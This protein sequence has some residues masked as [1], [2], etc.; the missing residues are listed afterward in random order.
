MSNRR[1]SNLLPRWALAVVLTGCLVTSSAAAFDSDRTLSRCETDAVQASFGIAA[2]LSWN[3][4]HHAIGPWTFASHVR[5]VCD[6]DGCRART[7]R[8]TIAADPDGWNEHDTASVFER[9]SV[10]ES[11]WFN[12]SA[13]LLAAMSNVTRVIYR[14]DGTDAAEIAQALPS[15]WTADDGSR[16]RVFFDDDVVTGIR[17]TARTSLA[18]AADASMCEVDVTTLIEVPDHASTACPVAFSASST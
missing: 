9:I 14:V 11:Q 17:I 3:G 8:A 4:D 18:C 10:P 6:E 13:A 15:G 7:G 2:T 1:K 5:I 16:R 12:E